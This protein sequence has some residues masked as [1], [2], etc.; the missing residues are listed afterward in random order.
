MKTIKVAKNG[1]L[2]NKN[3]AHAHNGILFSLKIGNAVIFYNI[4]ELREHYSK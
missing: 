3:V 4:D 2:D 1:W